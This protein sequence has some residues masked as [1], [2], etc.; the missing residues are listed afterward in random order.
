MGEFDLGGVA[1]DLDVTKSSTT[2]SVAMI[3]LATNL[4]HLTSKAQVLLIRF[5]Q[6]IVLSYFLSTRTKS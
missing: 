6:N 5:Q 4:E 2:P 1:I 3:P